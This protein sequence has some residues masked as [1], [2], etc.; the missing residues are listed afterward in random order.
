MAMDW[1][2]ISIFAFVL[3]VA[4]ISFVLDRARIRECVQA[5]GGKVLSIRWKRDW[6]TLVLFYEVK[7][8][9]VIKKRCRTSFFEGVLWQ[10]ESHSRF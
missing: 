2:V 10:D 9:E 3:I 4:A 6:S 7:N 1:S 5:K 8:G